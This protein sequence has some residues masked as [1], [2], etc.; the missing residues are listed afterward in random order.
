MSCV[1]SPFNIIK[2][3][4]ILENF[5]SIKRR[6]NPDI[7]VACMLREVATISLFFRLAIS[8]QAAINQMRALFLDITSSWSFSYVEIDGTKLNTI[9]S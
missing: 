5:I 8:D 6:E 7:P 2:K 4:M 9:A 3:R 1:S